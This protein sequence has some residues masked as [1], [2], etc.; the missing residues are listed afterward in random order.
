MGPWTTLAND[1][2][3]IAAIGAILAAAVTGNGTTEVVGALAGL[4]GY[5]TYKGAKA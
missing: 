1:L 3:T 2:V 5:R 4:G